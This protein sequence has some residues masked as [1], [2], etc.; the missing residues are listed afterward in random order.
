MQSRPVHVFAAVACVVVLAECDDY[1]G[2]GLTPSVRSHVLKVQGTGGG[3]G[4]VTSPD[5]S[6][7]I[8]CTITFGALS[9]Q[10]ANGYPSNSAVRL[11]ATPNKGSAFAGWSGACA[12]GSDCVVDMSQERTVTASFGPAT[13]A[14]Q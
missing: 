8:S 1:T 2:G 13:T 9:G 11:V 5:A 6:P 3:S 14:V 12:G 7:E 4:T 10:C